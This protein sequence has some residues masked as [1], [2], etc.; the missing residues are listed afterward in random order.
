V[1]YQ[2]EYVCTDDV[3]RKGYCEESQVG[4]YI[5]DLPAG[6]SVSDTSIYSTSLLFPSNDDSTLLASDSLGNAKTRTSYNAVAM[7]SQRKSLTMLRQRTKNSCLSLKN[8]HGTLTRISQVQ[9]ILHQCTRALFDTLCAK[10]AITVSVS[11]SFDIARF[12]NIPLV[13]AATAI[14]SHYLDPRHSYDIIFKNTHNGELSA[15]DFPSLIVRHYW[16]SRCISTL[17]RY[18]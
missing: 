3:V 16:I 9:S 1:F 10:Q 12:Y 13:L 5:L 15:M 17:M 4:W 6:K 14:R 11:Q 18:T 8:I 2:E 7:A